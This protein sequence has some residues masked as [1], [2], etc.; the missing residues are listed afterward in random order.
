MPNTEGAESK[1]AEDAT[2][3]VTALDN[4][5]LTSE[6]LLS[7][8]RW[9][10]ASPIVLADDGSRTEFALPLLLL[11]ERHG[12]KYLH[13]TRGGKSRA[14]NLAA[15][16]VETGVTVLCDNDIAVHGS[17]WLPKH[18]A[19]LERPGEGLP[20]VGA[21][22]GYGNP[23]F[24][25]VAGQVYC[26]PSN[27]GSPAYCEVVNGGLVTALTAT[28]RRVPHDEAYWREYEEYA[29]HFRLREAG[30]AVGHIAVPM[31]HR[32][33]HNASG[34]GLAARYAEFS[35]QRNRFLGQH[36]MRLAPMRSSA[37]VRAYMQAGR[38]GTP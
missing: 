25:D 30:L 34:P 6:C 17:D 23:D 13:L 14:I 31:T 38:W 2:F 24:V 15:G 35:A 20:R 26:D 9:F 19:W 32:M 4:V 28:L 36:R 7:I 16:L 29:W 27:D 21:I 12:A 37:E 10:P 8:R 11:A 18:R 3:L 1:G 5:A 33:C 22:G